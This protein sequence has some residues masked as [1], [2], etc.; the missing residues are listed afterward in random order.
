M[1]VFDLIG[2]GVSVANAFRRIMLSEVP[3][4]AADKVGLLEV[5][6]LRAHTRCVHIMRAQKI[7]SCRS[8]E[9][10][11]VFYLCRREDKS[12]GERTSQVVSAGLRL[13]T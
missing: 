2:V 7:G 1:V 5:E 6:M 11:W 13:I 3:T 12:I 9:S 10:V 4:L 8:R